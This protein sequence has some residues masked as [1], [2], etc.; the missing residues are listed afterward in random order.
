MSFK[1]L[2]VRKEIEIVVPV[3]A[4]AANDGEEAP[5]PVQS[6]H[7]AHSG[8]GN[9]AL[10]ADLHI[11]IFGQCIDNRGAHAM[12]PAACLVGGIIKLTSGMKGCKYKIRSAE[13]PFLCMPYRRQADIRNPLRYLLITK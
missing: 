3:L 9:T 1:N 10:T 6:V 7:R 12:K 11:Q 8:R 5:S 13:M 4:G 2:L